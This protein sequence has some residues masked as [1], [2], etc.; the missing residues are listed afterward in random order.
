MAGWSHSAGLG[1]PRH[2]NARS[3]PTAVITSFHEMVG[4]YPKAVSTLRR[5]GGESAYAEA[6]PLGGKWILE[7]FGTYD[8]SV[9]KPIGGAR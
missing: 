4:P 6:L 8:L 1:D 7:A 3:R 9:S 2:L 5:S